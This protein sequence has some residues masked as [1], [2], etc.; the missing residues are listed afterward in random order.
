MHSLRRRWI[1]TAAA[2]L[3]LSSA[4]FLIGNQ[5]PRG[6][7]FDEFHHVPEATDLLVGKVERPLVQ[8]PLARYVTALG[9][10][11]DANRPFGW[12]WTSGIFGALTLVG[13]Y[14]WA[15]GLFQSQATAL[16]AVI[17]AAVNQAL[18]VQARIAMP[19][20][21]LCALLVWALALYTAFWS[22]GLSRR[23][24]RRLLL[25]SGILFG[26]AMST[27]WSAA[28]PWLTC[29]GLFAAVRLLQRWEARFGADLAWRERVP[30]HRDWYSP[31]LW[32]N[33]KDRVFWLHLGL[34]PLLVYLAA[35]APLLLASSTIGVQDLWSLQ[36]DIARSHLQP[37]AGHPYASAWYE[38]PLMLKP[39]W[40]AFD[41]EGS[42]KAW[43]RGVVLLGNP[44]V[45]W[46]GLL[47]IGFS[48][49][50]WVKHRSL[51]GFLLTAF[52]GSLWLSWALIPARGS[53]F[54]HYIPA[55]LVLGLSLTQA[56]HC[57][58]HLR[59]R[60]APLRWIFLAAAAA[61][62]VYF[63]PLLAALRIPAESFRG[64]MW[65]SGWI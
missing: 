56:G 31:S 16:W 22:P 4:L 25:A 3:T 27:K 60:V 42:G 43:V 9:I 15:L 13:L 53:F 5:F 54:Y 18:Y 55:M 6:H 10:A 64:W 11:V 35:F 38:W 39:I 7:N 62:F 32:S 52:F 59:P 61:V 30:G 36:G 8:P 20:I 1:L 24:A 21:V 40:Y 37:K 58:V 45:L 41:K 44:F 34:L 57:L 14:F 47:S 17:L 50:S 48:I 19:D 49:W 29:L 65:F 23:K 2:V 28:A 12:R 46:G 33:L 26:L 63:F 51:A